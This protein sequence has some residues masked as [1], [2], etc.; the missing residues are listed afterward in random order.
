MSESIQTPQYALKRFFGYDQFRPNQ[1]EAIQSVLDK[2]DAFVLMPTGG[3]KSVCYH[4]PAIIQ[5]GI[6]IVVSPLIALMK[7]QVEGLKANGIKA[8]YLNSTLSAQEELTVLN[9]ANT[10]GIDILYLSPE[11]LLSGNFI[12]QIAQ[13]NINLFAI[14]EAHCISS[15]GHDFRPEYTQLNILKQRFPKTPVIALTATADS[16]TQNDICKQLDL[17]QPDLYKA[18]FNRSN[19]SLTV[20]PGKDKF[21]TISNFIHQR[22]GQCGII[23]C[24]SRKNTE[25]LSLKL[26]KSGIKA[27]HYHAGLSTDKRSKTQEDFIND[28]IDIICAT[29]AF[30]M[31]IDKSNVRW[32]MHYNLP[33]N[34][35]GYY[36][37]I[38]RAGR[39]GLPS[40]TILFYSY[41]DVMTIQK[42]LNNN[43]NAKVQL[44]KLERMQQYADALICRRKI[45]LNYFDELLEENCG[46]CDVCLN[47][48]KHFNGTVIV[49]KALSAVI[50]LQEQVATGMLIDVLRGSGKAEVIERG[51]NQ[52]KTFGA[53][54]DIAYFDWQQYIHQMINLGIF[55]VAYDEFNAL[56]IT[57]K[58]YSI[59]NNRS[60]TELVSLTD[61]AARIEKT[62]KVKKKTKKEEAKSTLFD[63][64][65][66]LRKTIANDENIPAYLI[67]TDATL[68]E[69]ADK[70]PVSG[71][72][73]LD[74]SGVGQAKLDNY[75][76]DFINAILEFVKAKQK[77]GSSVKKGSTFLVTLELY[78]Q[79][80]SVREIANERDLNPMT[81]YSHLSQLYEKGND[82]DISRFI[83]PEELDIVTA[84]IAKIGVPKTLKEMFEHLEGKLE[85]HKIRF[86]I[87]YHN[88]LKRAD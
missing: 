51:Y 86:G 2:K 7:D 63:E 87:S 15:W 73:M 27:A 33:K 42:I 45:L 84:A 8:A 60:S 85:Y 29:I 64:L 80:L 10:G 74:I 62:T 35:E 82:I 58:G 54:G 61:M 77:E 57:E 76:T 67:F 24:L 72:E 78:H 25:Q 47:P 50:R 69:M 49:L 55:K 9:M 48:P 71:E 79:G 26:K 88:K 70:K 3:G 56:K 66:A 46:N 52:I 65:K 39:D 41:A 16:L 36:Q 12:E 6:G 37:E 18:S 13:M 44:A 68:E 21:K 19:L 11:R 53:G 30:G 17:D 31:G 14:D 1:A 20:L 81:I 38:G 32:V 43:G 40:S 4:I 83:D 23:Y 22:Q 28:K 59:L 5:Q 34:I 75:G